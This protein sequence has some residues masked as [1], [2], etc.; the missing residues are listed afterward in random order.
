MRKFGFLVVAILLAGIIAGGVSASSEYKEVQENEYWVSWDGSANVS[1]KTMFYSPEEMVNQTKESILKMGIENA[2]KVFISQEQQVLSQLGLTLEN[3][4][5]EILGYDTPGPLVTVI[6][7]TIPHF[8]RYYS[9][10]NAWE[11]SL[12]A[13]RIADLSRIDPTAIN[14]SMYLENYFTVHLPE[15]ANVENVTKGFKAESNGSYI[16]L[17]VKVDGTTI[18]AHSVIYFKEGVTKDDLRVLYSKLEPLIIKY[19][20]KTGV[21]NYTTWEMRIYNNITVNGDETILDTTEEYVKPESYINYIKVQFA[22]QGLQT[23]EQNLYQSYAQN[24]QSKGI[25]VISGNVSILNVNST[26]PLVVKYHWVL[27]GFVSKEN[28]TYVYV[29]DPKLELGNLNFP[30]RFDAAINETKVTRIKLPEGYEF[31]ELP[32]NIEVKTDAG[33]VVMKVTKLNDREILIESNVYIR[34]GVPADAYR[35]LMAQIPDDVE[36]KYVVKAE[37]ANGVCG[38]AFVVGLAVLPLLLRRRR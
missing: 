17:D 4:S 13:L 33:S 24:F 34:Y 26:S 29:Y 22:Y 6:N 12:D 18:T 21:E 27:Q 2:T 20:G 30:Y 38:P 1:L 5:A 19:T 23:A 9:Y 31:K 16:Q 35:A 28:N 32:Q 8:A 25:R 15:G 14:S 36:F 7:G 3:A 11:V 10:D 37:E